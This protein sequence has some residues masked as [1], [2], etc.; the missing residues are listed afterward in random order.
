MSKGAGFGLLFLALMIIAR[1]VASQ[2]ETNEMKQLISSCQ[3]NISFVEEGRYL[4]ELEV[5]GVSHRLD[6]GLVEDDV[7][8]WADGLTK[9]AVQR[10]ALL[11]LLDGLCVMMHEPKIWRPKVLSIE[12]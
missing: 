5:F 11:R 2:E 12:L 9:G 4:V 1:A 7:D 6:V 3:L 8:M 10:E